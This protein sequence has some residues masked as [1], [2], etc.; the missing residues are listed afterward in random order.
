MYK[1]SDL[2]TLPNFEIAYDY[3]E[4]GIKVAFYNDQSGKEK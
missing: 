2:L 4:M 1:S 3:P